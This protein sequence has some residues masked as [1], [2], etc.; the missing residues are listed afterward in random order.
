MT[1]DPK[2]ARAD[3]LKLQAKALQDGNLDE[4]KRLSSMLEKTGGAE[5]QKK[6]EPIEVIAARAAARADADPGTPHSQAGE[7]QPLPAEADAE[8]PSGPDPD[9]LAAV[10]STTDILA[11]LAA[12]GPAPT[13]ADL[14]AWLGSPGN[15]NCLFVY[16]GGARQWMVDG[17]SLVLG[18]MKS[19]AQISAPV[20]NGAEE[21]VPEIGFQLGAGVQAVHA[22]WLAIQAGRD[23]DPLGAPPLGPVF[24]QWLMKLSEGRTGIHPLSMLASLVTDWQVWNAK[25]TPVDRKREGI[26]PVSLRNARQGTLFDM[27]PDS[28]DGE[29]PLGQLSQH[30]HGILPGFD[31]TKSSVVPVLPIQLYMLAGGKLT[32][33]GQGAPISQR[34]MFELL[35][36]AYRLLRSGER[37]PNTT[38]R[39]L[40]EWV[41]PNGWQRGRDL[42]RLQR[43]LWELDNMRIEHE[44]GLWRLISLDRLPRLDAFLDD[45]IPFRIIHLPDSERGPLID[46]HRLRLYGLQSAP[47]WRAYLRLAYIWDA[48][49]VSNGGYRVYATRPAVKRGRGGVLLD[50]DG[51]PVLKR[52]GQAVKDWSDV[53]AVQLYD[54]DGKPALE[55]NPAADRVPMLNPDEIAQLGFDEKTNRGN[56]KK[57]TFLTREALTQ[58]E[59]DSAI[60]LE[61]DGDYWRILEPP[62]RPT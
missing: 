7:A 15:S 45:P 60:V 41:W 12:G 35:M 46:R 43:A 20:K 6:S 21:L 27:P 33:R 49:K 26:L 58:M 17:E 10:T 30:G 16:E 1:N 47:A 31:Q 38:L 23:P 52:N 11:A 14:C 44:R 55:R 53:R 32:T 28:L 39:D 50:V 2:Y 57:R 42:P 5:A 61:K 25:Q 18:T 34:L 59:K 51:K 54:A 62:P 9:A 22:D 8:R 40:V 48:A 37:I 56:R 24:L 4:A 13:E 3:L 19:W 36:S 29:T